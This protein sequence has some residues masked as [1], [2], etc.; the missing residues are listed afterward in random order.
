MIDVITVTKEIPLKSTTMGSLKA[1]SAYQRPTPKMTTL[2]FS[3]SV[4]FE[5]VESDEMDFDGTLLVD[6]EVMDIELIDITDE[7]DTDMLLEC[8]LQDVDC[9]SEV[10]S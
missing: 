3:Y 10:Y 2:D 8:L 4:E 9:M 6:L 1:L 7:N 5:M